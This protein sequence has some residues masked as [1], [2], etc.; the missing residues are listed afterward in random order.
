L[1][2]A[3]AFCLTNFKA[4]RQTFNPDLDLDLWQ[5]PNNVHL[6]MHN[7]YITLSHLQSTNG[8]IIIWNIIMQDISKANFKKDH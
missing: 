2:L 5:T 7:T 3:L 1:P 8:L 4:Q 6:N